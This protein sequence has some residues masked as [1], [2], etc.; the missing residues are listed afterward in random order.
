M[1]GFMVAHEAGNYRQLFIV[2]SPSRERACAAVQRQQ[3]NCPTYALAPVSD[4]TLNYMNVSTEIPLRIHGHQC[5]EILCC[6]DMEGVAS[7]HVEGM[8]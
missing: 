8:A 7:G 6:G 5:N 1:S 2:R 4:V 3:G